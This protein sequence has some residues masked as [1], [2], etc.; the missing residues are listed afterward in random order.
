MKKTNKHW[1]ALILALCACAWLGHAAPSVEL[2]SIYGH[3][4]V[5]RLIPTSGI[6]AGPE[7]LKPWVGTHISY[8]ASAAKFGKQ[9]IKIPRYNLRRVSAA[10]F[11][12]ENKIRLK[13]VGIRAPFVFEIDVVDDR[14]RDVHVKGPGAFV[15]VRD[16]N[17][18]VTFWDGGAFEMVRV[19]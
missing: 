10:D 16:A 15:L 18:L 13:E 8:S 3:W 17:H 11:F 1:L 2:S 7:V 5:K 4:V 9:A 12:V 6:S 14:G 19:K